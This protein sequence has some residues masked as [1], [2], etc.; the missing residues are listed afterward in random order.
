MYTNEK[1]NTYILKNRHSRN[2]YI[3]MLFTS[4]NLLKKKPDIIILSIHTSR[5]VE[6]VKI[7]SRQFTRIIS[8]IRVS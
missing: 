4:E 5:Q 6:T 2:I 8:M 1:I 7:S 3:R